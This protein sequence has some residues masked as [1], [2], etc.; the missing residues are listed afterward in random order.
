MLNPTQFQAKEE[1]VQVA[2]DSLSKTDSPSEWHPLSE[3]YSYSN[4]SNYLF[5]VQAQHLVYDLFEDL[6]DGWMLISLLEVLA[7]RQFVSTTSK[8]C[9][10]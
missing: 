2:D 10:G 9:I 3:A 7:H 6:R 8:F 1:K 5:N 4:Y